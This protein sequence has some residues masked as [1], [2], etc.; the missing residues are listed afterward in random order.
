MKLQV[1]TFLH[2][3]IS[4]Y[5]CKNSS[6]LPLTLYA[7]LMYSDF[8]FYKSTSLIF[9]SFTKLKIVVGLHTS[10][11]S[12]LLLLLFSLQAMSDSLRPFMDCSTLSSSFTSLL[13]SINFLSYREILLIICESYLF[14]SYF[15]PTYMF[16]YSLE[17][18]TGMPK[19]H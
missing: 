17:L 12:I 2:G 10:F 5:S 4:P 16:W 3:H 15:F 1:L 13:L 9:S 19:G 8:F 11:L 6:S 18:W 7:N 14:P